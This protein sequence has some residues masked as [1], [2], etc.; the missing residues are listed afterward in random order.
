MSADDKKNKT[1]WRHAVLVTLNPRFAPL[2]SPFPRSSRPRKQSGRNL[3]AN[4]LRQNAKNGQPVPAEALEFLAWLVEE[5]TRNRPPMPAKIRQLN[6]IARKTNL[7]IAVSDFREQR[8][9]WKADNPRT[10]FPYKAKLEEV[11]DQWRIDQDTLNNAI[12]RSRKV[13]T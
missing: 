13:P 11:A 8:R 6:A 10:K 7:L 4:L 1:A 9:E 5:K 12:R 3:L 2:V